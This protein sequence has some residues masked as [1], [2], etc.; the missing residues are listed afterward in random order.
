MGE[1]FSRKILSGN[2]SKHFR[3]FPTFRKNFWQETF[4]ESFPENCGKLFPPT[5]RKETAQN[6]PGTFPEKVGTFCQNSLWKRVFSPQISGGNSGGFLTD[7]DSFP[8]N[9]G[10]K[11]P[12]NSREFRGENSGFFSGFFYV[13][14]LQRRVAPLKN[15]AFSGE[16]P[17]EILG[18]QENPENSTELFPE[19]FSEKNFGENFSEISENFRKFLFDFGKIRVFHKTRFAEQ[20]T[21]P[22]ILGIFG[23]FCPFFDKNRRKFRGKIPRKIPRKIGENSGENFPGFF[24]NPLCVAGYP[25]GKSGGKSGENFPEISGISENFRKKKGRKWPFLVIFTHFCTRVFGG[26]LLRS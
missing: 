12:G 16:I 13:S 24:R 15:G 10:G 19:N 5:S 8:E 20:G 14:R 6:S 1:T 3:N 4:P 18:K 25:A 21:H 7:P 23:H 22:K 11:F 26:T 2:F 9:P 17:G